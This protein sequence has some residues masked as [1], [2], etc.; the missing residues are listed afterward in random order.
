MQAFVAGQTPPSMCRF[1]DVALIFAGWL[2]LVC[3]GGVRSRLCIQQPSIRLII[4]QCID[5]LSVFVACRRQES[6]CIVETRFPYPHKWLQCQ[7]W[8]EMNENTST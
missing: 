5:V 3:T 8:I 4:R 1:I 2:C 6:T 7:K